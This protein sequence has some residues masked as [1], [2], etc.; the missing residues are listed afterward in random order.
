MKIF[1]EKMN[2]KY[3]DFIKKVDEKNKLLNEAINKLA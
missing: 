1:K 3:S 2:Q